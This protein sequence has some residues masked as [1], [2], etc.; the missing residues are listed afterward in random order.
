[1]DL[2]IVVRLAGENTHV[3]RYFKGDW[4]HLDRNHANTSRFLS[5]GTRMCLYDLGSAGGTPP[6]FCWI[7]EG[8]DLVNFEPD[9]G[10]E[11]EGFGITLPVAI[12]PSNLDRIYLN[13]RPTTSSLLPPYRPIIDR[14]DFSHLFGQQGIFDTV[15]VQ[16][17][18]TV[19]LDDIVGSRG[20]P[21]A[22]FLK[23]D[24]QGLSF[25][26]LQSAKTVLSDSVLG[27]QIEVEFLE[28]YDGQKTFG[29]V[30]EYLYDNGFEI[31]EISNINQ[32]YY[33][34]S[35]PLRNLKGQ[36]VFCDLLYLR[37]MDSLDNTGFWNPD[38]A[39]KFMMVCLLYDLTDTA[40]AFLEKSS[41]AGL[42]K[43]DE[44]GE[45]ESL[46]V[47]W[48]SA[49]GF[50]FFTE[51]PERPTWIDKVL[52]ASPRRILRVMLP[53]KLRN[54]LGQALRHL[55]QVGRR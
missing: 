12:G 50:F 18:K 37:N 47:N 31:F 27:L 9:P 8:I 29:V 49:L 1:V 42:L 46:V 20:L 3:K 35:L 10:A 44:Y 7:L 5:L 23:I 28:T 51:P 36:D 16:E 52:D 38:R 21:P 55:R 40:A 17:V 15:D 22:D 13:R 54:H 2:R 53:Q 19:G 39:V 45:L 43:G 26:V 24:V 33:R 41:A 48:E 11:S 25:E 32:W 4:L 14:Y 30:H 6:P 34:T